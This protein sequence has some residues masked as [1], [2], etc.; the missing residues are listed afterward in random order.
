MG[1][2]KGN[3]EGAVGVPPLGRS[4]NSRDD[5]PAS[6]GRGV[7]VDIVGNV[8]VGGIIMAN[9]G[10]FLEAEGYHCGIYCGLIHL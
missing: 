7:V 2:D 6:R 9:E 4:E 10:V 1:N 8:L 3:A 5:S